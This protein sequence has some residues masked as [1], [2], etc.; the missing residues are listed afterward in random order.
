MVVQTIDDINHKMELEEQ[1]PGPR[2]GSHMFSS[3]TNVFFL[4]KNNENQYDYASV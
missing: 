2:G 3:S 1:T 4:K